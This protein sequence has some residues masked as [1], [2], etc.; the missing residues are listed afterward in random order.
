MHL[1]VIIKREV[2]NLRGLQGN[3]GR[4]EGEEGGMK[5]I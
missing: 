2:M 1:T 4:V 5:V 3:M